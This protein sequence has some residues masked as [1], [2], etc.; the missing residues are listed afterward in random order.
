MTKSQ[1]KFIGIDLKIYICTIYCVLCMCKPV[2]LIALCTVLHVSKELDRVYW[3]DA[4]LDLLESAK[5][6]NIKGTIKNHSP[7]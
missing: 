4:K 2:R 7:F 6:G 1:I 3:S 5:L